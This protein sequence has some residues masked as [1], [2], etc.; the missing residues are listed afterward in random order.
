MEGGGGEESLFD[1]KEVEGRGG[2]WMDALSLGSTVF[3]S[4]LENGKK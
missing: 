3:A 1:W 2:K 4:F